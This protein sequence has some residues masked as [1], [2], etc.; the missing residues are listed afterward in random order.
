MIIE[1]SSILDII[2][3]RSNRDYIPFGLVSIIYVLLR[4]VLLLP[5]K[6]KLK[7]K[8]KYKYR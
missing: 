4:L 7:Y 5:K 6:Y 3:L 1:Q 2:F 8:L